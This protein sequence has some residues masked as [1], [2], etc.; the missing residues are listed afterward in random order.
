MNFNDLFH[1]NENRM[2]IPRLKKILDYFEPHGPG[3]MSP[4]FISTNVF[5]KNIRILKDAHLKLTVTQPHNDVAIE[6]IGFNLADKEMLVAMGIPFEM[7]FT[8]ETNSFRERETL[9][10]NIKD[11]R[12]N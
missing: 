2:K 9:Q 5:T 10:L 12:E 3:N 6:A 11:I 7:A 4:V 8:L 1:P